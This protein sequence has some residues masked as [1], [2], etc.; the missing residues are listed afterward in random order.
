VATRQRRRGPELRIQQDRRQQRRRC[1]RCR[2]GVLH[3]HGRRDTDPNKLRTFLN[4]GQGQT[5]PV[6]DSHFGHPPCSRASILV[7]VPNA[8]G[9]RTWRDCVRKCISTYG[10]GVSTSNSTARRPRDL[11]HQP[12][13][14]RRGSMFKVADV[15]KSGLDYN[16][17]N[18]KRSGISS[19]KNGTMQ[20][21]SLSQR[22]L[23]V[24]ECR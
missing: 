7:H 20:G 23:M 16:R 24:D 17:V 21:G 12:A 8:S 3:P 18:C 4:A 5:P 15:N 14:R 11:Y 22:V 9:M 10:D 2:H 13:V 6:S 19:S 1:Q